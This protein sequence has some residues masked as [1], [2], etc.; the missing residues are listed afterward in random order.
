MTVLGGWRRAA[1]L[2]AAGLI[3]TAGV[4]SGGSAAAQGAPTQRVT[5]R[6]VDQSGAALSPATAFACPYVSGAPDCSQLVAAEAGRNGV[7]RLD[8]ERDVRYEITGFVSDP[9]PEWACDGFLFNGNELYFSKNRIDAMPDDISRRAVLIVVRPEVH[10]CVPIT[11]VD[12]AGNPLTSAGMIVCPYA[13]DGTPCTEA[14]FDQA[15]ADGIIRLDVEPSVRYNLTA[16]VADATCG[17]FRFSA[18]RDALGDE[19][20]GGA[21]FVIPRPGACP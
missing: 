9:E 1:A 12:D 7:V 6:V 5:V 19:L 20:V 2:L 17:G 18:P 14:T 11:V 10:D 21:T 16:F 4:G 8:L 3:V 15:D 13:Q